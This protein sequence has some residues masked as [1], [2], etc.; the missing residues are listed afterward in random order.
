MNTLTITSDNNSNLIVN[1]S[2][3]AESLEVEQLNV[4]DDIYVN[5]NRYTP[6]GSILNYAGPTAPNG[7]LLCDGSEV[8]KT[9]Y[10]RLFSIIGNLY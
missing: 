4:T 3:I 7:W 6:V 9:T 2:I 8:S 5:N 1:N 10:S